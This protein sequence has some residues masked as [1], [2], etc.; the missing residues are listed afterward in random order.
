MDNVNTPYLLKE[1]LR[2]QGFLAAAKDL[3]TE[4]MSL[5]ELQAALRAW[6]SYPECLRHFPTKLTRRT[7]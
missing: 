6:G 3:E 7:K 4:F 2:K 1:A 5:G